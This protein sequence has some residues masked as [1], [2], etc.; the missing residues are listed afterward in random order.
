L[1]RAT[2]GRNGQGSGRHQR[3]TDLAVVGGIVGLGYMVVLATIDGGWM[4]GAPAFSVL[5][6]PAAGF[7]AWRTAMPWRRVLL[8]TAIFGGAFGF[9]FEMFQESGQSYSVVATSLPKLLGVVPGDSVVAHMCM[10]L[11]TLTFYEHFVLQREPA[12][13]AAA[14]ADLSARARYGIG[15]G[16]TMVVAV[17]VAHLIEPSWVDIGYSYAVLGTAAI[18]PPVLL[19]LKRPAWLRNLTLV[20]PVFF[21]SYVVME[22]VA[23]RHDWWIYPAD[24]YLGWVTLPG[25]V[26]DVRF[27][28]EELFYWMAFYAAA[29]TSYYEIFLVPATSN[30]LVTPSHDRRLP[31]AGS[32]EKGPPHAITEELAGR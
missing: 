32:R 15:L 9:F 17:V 23:V 26:S 11:L 13:A 8:G 22:V 6:L 7:L 28:F 4:E 24:H 30:A 12:N 31:S 2:S 3:W 20:V 25:P 10:T 27:P 14:T 21:A 29:L 1:G 16:T 18:L 19:A 5:T